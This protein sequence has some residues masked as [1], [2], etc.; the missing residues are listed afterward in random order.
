M[1]PPIIPESWIREFARKHLL[2]AVL[3]L[4]YGAVIVGLTVYDLIS[5]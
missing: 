1:I 2:T 4:L 5:K 3:I